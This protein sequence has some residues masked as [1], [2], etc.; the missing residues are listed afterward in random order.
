[1]T[2]TELQQEVITL[3]N[4]PDLA[5]ETLL[6]V[7][8]STLALHQMDYWWKDVKESGISFST[9]EY[10]QEIEYRPIIPRFRALKYVRKSDVSGA[11]LEMI[12]VV[13]PESVLDAYGTNRVDVA[14]AAGQSIE[15]RSSTLLQYCI[16]GYYEHPN[17]TPTG[18][19][20]WIAEDHP[21]AIVFEAAEKVFKMIGKSEEFAAY[22]LLRDEEKQRLTISNVQAMGY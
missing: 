10:L 14:Y 5:A 4:R 22:K 3:T 1:M 13:Q 17:I 18:F 16:L 2:L 20:S 21:Y 7:R 12:T 11:G 15:I 19:S 8:Q 6:A 9:P